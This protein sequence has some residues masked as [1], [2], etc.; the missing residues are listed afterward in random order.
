MGESLPNMIGENENISLNPS[1]SVFLQIREGLGLSRREFGELLGVSGK[2][3]W[4]WEKRQAHHALSIPQVKQIN[5][6]L[7]RLGL[8]WEDFPDDAGLPDVYL[9]QSK[10]KAKGLKPQ[11]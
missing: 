5:R 11:T 7:Q 9:K 6:C 8:T 1:V 2:T 4:N 10:Q 3:I